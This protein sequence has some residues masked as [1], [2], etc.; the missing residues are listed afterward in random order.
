MRCGSL[1]R[2]W[3]GDRRGGT[4][5]PPFSIPQLGVT[6]AHLQT[7]G[8]TQRAASPHPSVPLTR[9]SKKSERFLIPPLLYLLPCA[10]LSGCTT[11]EE[12]GKHLVPTGRLSNFLCFYGLSQ[13]NAPFSATVLARLSRAHSLFGRKVLPDRDLTKNQFYDE[14]KCGC[15]G[16]EER[17]DM[18]PIR[19]FFPASFSPLF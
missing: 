12:E 14:L 11:A 9:G 3:V 16:K 19:S 17:K 10:H 18:G 1:S 8:V 6:L 15:A 2:A 4:C 5:D 13:T 7:P